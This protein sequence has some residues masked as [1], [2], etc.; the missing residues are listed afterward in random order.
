MCHCGE[1][2]ANY[3]PHRVN[4]G[5][6]KEGCAGKTLKEAWADFETDE[7]VL[8]TSKVQIVGMYYADEDTDWP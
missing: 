2:C 6:C 5:E 1:D 7:Q 3:C 8:R 4:V